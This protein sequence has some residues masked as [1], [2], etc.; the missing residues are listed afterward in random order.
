MNEINYVFALI[1]TEEQPLG[2]F[3]GD[4]EWVMVDHKLR[5]WEL[6]GGRVHEGESFEDAIVRE[7]FEETGLTAKIIQKPMK[8]DSGLVFLMGLNQSE[9]NILN[10]SKD[11]IINDA[12][13]FSKPPNKLAWGLEELIKIITSFN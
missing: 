1:T 5:G 12:R 10:P 13:W 3:S 11:P 6:P 9:E 4:G 8:I 7:V 2:D